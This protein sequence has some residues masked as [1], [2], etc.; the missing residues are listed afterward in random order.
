MQWKGKF[1]EGAL[2]TLCNIVRDS[3]FGTHTLKEAWDSKWNANDP[4]MQKAYRSGIKLMM[5]DFIMLLLFGFIATGLLGDWAEEEK[6]HAKK[7]GNLGDAG[8][9]TF[10]NI[11]HR[12]MK[13]ASAD[14]NWIKSIFDV[15]LDANPFALASLARTASSVA[16]MVMGD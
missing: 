13:N 15:T 12:T 6:K 2:V 14:F 9:A 11:A 8:V 4:D 3:V 7:T 5:T 10:A 16:D 1:E